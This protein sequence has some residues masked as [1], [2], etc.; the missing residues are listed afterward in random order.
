MGCTNGYEVRDQA[1]EGKSQSKKV[2]A[3][4]TYLSRTMVYLY[5]TEAMRLNSID[6]EYIKTHYQ[7]S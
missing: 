6:K 2:L 7:S 5:N 4:L 1:R 3:N